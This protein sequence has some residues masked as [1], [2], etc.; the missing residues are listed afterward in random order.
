M[1]VKL[2]NMKTRL[3]NVR[4]KLGNMKTRLGNVRPLRSF[5]A[6]DKTRHLQLHLPGPCNRQVCDKTEHQQLYWSWLKDNQFGMYRAEMHRAR[7]GS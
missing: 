5:L 1:R 2:R 6:V 7:E 4:V 3:G